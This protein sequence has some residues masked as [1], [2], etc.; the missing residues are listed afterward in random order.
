MS[1]KDFM[2]LLYDNPDW[3]AV[4]FGWSMMLVVVSG[5]VWLVVQIF[6]NL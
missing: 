3:L 2:D 1:L 6:K 4:V 5:A